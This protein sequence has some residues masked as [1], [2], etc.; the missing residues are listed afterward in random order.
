M[1]ITKVAVAGGTGN[2]GPAVVNALVEA[3]FQVTL[4]SRSSTH[5][6]DSRV[7]IQVVDYNSLD[8]LVTALTGQ[9][10]VVDVLPSGSISVEI[11]LRLIEAAHKAGVQ[12]FI[13]SE[14]G[15]DTSHPLTSKLPVFGDKVTVV[16]RLKEISAQDSAFTYTPV[17]TGPFFDWGL[18]M[19][20]TVNLSGPS[21]PIYDGGDTPFSTT[22][23][24]GIG[25]AI[26]GVLEHPDETKNRYVYVSQAE[27][28][29]NKL[30]A[31]SGKTVEREDISTADLEKKAYEAVKLSPPDF[32]TFAVNLIRL[33]VFNPAYGSA[34]TKTD[35]ELLGVHKFSEAE[36]VDLVKQYS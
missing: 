9:D 6:I 15:C 19:K 34:F 20:F 26:A 33:A 5:E 11:P 21:T 4:L 2:L 29:Q 23:L 31:L 27:V 30:L 12:R 16:N 14:Y 10:A 28:T 22:T 1:A 35:N 3:N 17:I 25:R 24:A 7:K 32:R 13:P 36:I 18:K 8:S